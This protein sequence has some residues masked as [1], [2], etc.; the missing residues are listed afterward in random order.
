MKIALNDKNIGARDNSDENYC[1]KKGPSSEYFEQ[2]LI[3][4]W[5]MWFSY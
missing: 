5:L 1:V 3:L 2:F 4:G